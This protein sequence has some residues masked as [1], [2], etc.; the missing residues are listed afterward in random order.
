MR[1]QWI[2]TIAGGLA[3][4]VLGL[5]ALPASAD[6]AIT[7]KLLLKTQVGPQAV[8]AS[9]ALPAGSLVRLEVTANQDVTL[10][11]TL[12]P[13]QGEAK[14]LADDLTIAAGQ[15][16]TLPSA[17]GWLELTSTS[18]QDTF[19]IAATDAGGA[20]SQVQYSYLIIGDEL[21]A[22]DQGQFSNLGK[23]SANNTMSK[24]LGGTFS[25][26]NKGA[27]AF[28]FSS[29]PRQGFARQMAKVPAES[30]SFSAYTSGSALFKDVV[31]GVVLIL[32]DES[33]GSGS[34]IDNEGRII[35]NWHVVGDYA[36]VG[37][38]FRPPPGTPLTED[39]IM[40]ADVLATDKGHDLALLKLQEVPRGMKVLSL[41]SMAN[42]DIGNE[43]HA[44]GHPEGESWTYTRGY[45]S[46]VRDGYEWS[47][48]EN[49]DHKALVIQTQTP[50]SPG[51][52]GG[53]L[54]DEEGKIIGVNTFTSTTAQNINFAVAVTEVQN[55]VAGAPT[56][57]AAAPS[58]SLQPSQPSQPAQP[59]QAPLQ[60]AQPQPPAAPQPQQPA[61]EG[62]LTWW[63]L[64][65]D[66]NGTIDAW[67]ADRNGD[68]YYDA[69]IVDE[70]EDGNPDY[71]LFDDNFNGVIDAK[72]VPQ[73]D[74]QGPYD[75]WM[76]DDNEDGTA[77]IYGLDYNQDGEI[78]EWREA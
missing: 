20:V 6:D 47:Y 64:D 78:D 69:F 26:L 31:D 76:F 46:Q 22:M 8:G 70:N 3:A 16:A 60:P 67:G 58:P 55:F 50:I 7:A 66:S 30:N 35:T 74:E 13:D 62:E 48:G 17:D 56:E 21:V 14:V 39:M 11:V 72:L 40:L 12:T 23:G 24:D 61:P 49:D 27:K 52:S 44:I 19:T 57:V 34:V 29:D 5:A 42:V 73:E 4:L 25:V 15:T 32:T 1:L 63:E 54:F 53:P 45:I 2:K 28:N 18:G 43:V 9:D 38:V 51:S 65:S 37:V 59:P 10:D 33:L 75:V 41:G 36:V 77:D 71:A 68:G